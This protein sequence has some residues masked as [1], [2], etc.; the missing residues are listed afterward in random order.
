MIT[1]GAKQKEGESRLDLIDRN[2]G[3]LRSV[4]ESMKP[5]KEST[6]LLHVAN[7]VDILT[8]FAQKFSGLPHGQVI[9]SGTFLDSVRLRG[10]LSEDAGVAA[11]SIDAFVLGEHGE[12]QFIA[13]S[14]VAIAGV[15]IARALPKQFEKLD[16]EG[17][18]SD[19]KEKAG[20]IIESKGATS[21]GIGS[22]AS[23]ICENILFDKRTVR[24]VSR[25][26]QEFGCYLSLPAVLGRKGVV[27]GVDADLSEEERKKLK[28]SAESLRKIIRDSEE[29]QDKKDKSIKGS[30]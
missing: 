30:K 9:G 13:W 12:S 16:R 8:Y 10:L 18:A 19:V 24:P 22:V 5:F 4:I 1:A 7:P 11:S 28:Q 25:F 15:P 20:R 26:V 6:I 2:L 29:K 14:S 3:I 21:F 17:V 23:S 27:G